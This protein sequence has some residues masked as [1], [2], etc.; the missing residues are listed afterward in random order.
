[1]S[2]CMRGRLTRT[3]TFSDN[4]LKDVPHA[5]ESRQALFGRCQPGWGE[6]F[7]DAVYGRDDTIQNAL[8]K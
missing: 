8:E 6:L 1:M 2:E 7:S 5:Y 4:P 3:H